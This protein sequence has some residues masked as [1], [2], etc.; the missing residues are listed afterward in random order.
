ML[1]LNDFSNAY[2]KYFTIKRCYDEIIQILFVKLKFDI[3]FI[4]SS[5]FRTITQVLCKIQLIQFERVKIES[6]KNL[7]SHSKMCF[8][9]NNFN[10]FAMLN[11]LR[12]KNT[13]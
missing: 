9:W 11:K 4:M 7:N 8:F 2:S 1:I 13:A 10:S 3:I 12:N 5:N 6:H